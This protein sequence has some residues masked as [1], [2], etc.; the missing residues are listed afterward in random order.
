MYIYIYIYEFLLAVEAVPEVDGGL[1]LR[2]LL[3]LRG[4]MNLYIYIYIYIYIHIYI[5]IYIHMI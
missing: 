3:A 5:Y 1:L 4:V 2:L